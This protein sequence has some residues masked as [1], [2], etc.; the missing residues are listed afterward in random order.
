MKFFVPETKNYRVSGTFELFPQH[1]MLPDLSPADH[2]VAVKDEL[3]ESVQR[4]NKQEKRDLLQQLASALQQ[5]ATAS[6]PPAQRVGTAPATVG[7]PA[8]TEGGRATTEGRAP[9]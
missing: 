2:A 5:L 6:P 3:V 8:A 9:P 7:G 4:L 1:C